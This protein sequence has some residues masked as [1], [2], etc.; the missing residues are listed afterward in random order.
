MADETAYQEQFRYT[1]ILL[2]QERIQTRVR[3]MGAELSRRFRGEK[4]LLITLLKGG[5]I[6]LADLCRAMTIPHELDF[7]LVRSY[8]GT[9][10]T[11]TVQIIMDLKTNIEGRHVVLVEDIVDTG[12]T[13][14]YIRDHLA[15]RKPASLMVCC[16]LDKKEAREVDVPLEMV[17]FTVENEYLVGY[18]LDY[19]QLYRNLPFVAAI[20]PDQ[21]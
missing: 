3:E 7:M 9:T 18:G 10:T 12:L 15:L 6:F 17:G 21:A 5:F 14:E 16:L 1:R 8:E 20:D 2:R 11:G 13:L 4:P 19:N